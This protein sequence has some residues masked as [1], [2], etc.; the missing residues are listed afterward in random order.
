MLHW[1]QRNQ[2]IK[3][4]PLPDAR[5]PFGRPAPS[6]AA[7]IFICQINTLRSLALNLHRAGRPARRNVAHS[8][9]RQTDTG[10]SSAAAKNA[11]A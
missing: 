3:I 7:V 5:R 2:P 9:M 1:L 6:S 11:A 4:K 8:M 10:L